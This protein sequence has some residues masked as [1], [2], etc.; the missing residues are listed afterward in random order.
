[1]GGFAQFRIESP[2]T[3]ADGDSY[4]FDARGFT[5]LTVA[6]ASGATAVVSRVNSKDASAAQGSP[7]DLTPPSGGALSTYDVDWPYY[8]VS[9]TDAAVTVALA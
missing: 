7:Y 2:T 5:K 9:A 4:V 6:A 3:L 8:F 1:M